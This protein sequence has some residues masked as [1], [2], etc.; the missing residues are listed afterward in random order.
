MARNTDR[1][2]AIRRLVDGS[3]ELPPV[4]IRMQRAK[5]INTFRSQHLTNPIQQ[6]HV[7][8]LESNMPAMKAFP[9]DSAYNDSIIDA[10]HFYGA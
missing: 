1:R 2:R 9:D 8:V 4:P 7:D 10:G 6:V 3:R 5:N